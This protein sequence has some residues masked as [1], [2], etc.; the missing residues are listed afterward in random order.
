MSRVNVKVRSRWAHLFR[1]NGS[2]TGKKSTVEPTCSTN[3]TYTS[4]RIV[5]YPDS[6][7]QER[8]RVKVIYN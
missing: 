4:V 8:G 1:V 3:F 6:A 7:S 5:H 2:G